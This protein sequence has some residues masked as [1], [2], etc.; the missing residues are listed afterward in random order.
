MS[1]IYSLLRIN[2]DVIRDFPLQASRVDENQ[3]EKIINRN[4]RQLKLIEER[5]LISKGIKASPQSVDSVIKKV[6][7]LSAEN[8]IS[9]EN[10]SIRELRIISYYL[11]KL[12]SNYKDY[13]YALSLL[14]FNWRN[15]FF[16]GLVFYI[17]NS[18]NYIEDELRESTSQLIIKKLKEYKDNNRRYLLLKNHSNFFEKS[19]PK[20]MA[21]L[22]LTK[23]IDLLNAPQILGFKNTAIKQ[24]FY[25]DVILHY[26]A[27]KRIT[28]LEVIE[29]L[30]NI[31]DLDRTKKLVCASLVENANRN[32]DELTRTLLCRFINRTLGDVTL[33]STWAPFSGA[34]KEEA[35]RLKKA[36][37]LVY[38]WFAQRIIEVFFDVCVQ[39]KERKRFWLKYVHHLSGFKLVGSTATKRLLQGDSRIGSMFFKHFIETNSYKS[40]TSA[41]ILFVKNK[42]MVEFSDT[43]ALYVYN[44]EHSQVK[45]VNSH[46]FINSTNDLKIPS[47]QLLVESDYYYTHHNEEGRLHHRGDWQ[48]RLTYWLNDKVLSQSNNNISFWETKDDEIFKETPLTDNVDIYEDD[49]EEISASPTLVSQEV[50]PDRA[51]EEDDDDSILIEQNLKYRISSKWF[52]NK[53]RIVANEKGF[54]VNVL[55]QSNYAK[56]KSFKAGE[57]PSGDIWVRKTN[58]SNWNEVALFCFGTIT[59]IGYINT[60]D[61]RILFKES[62]EL[63][64]YKEIRL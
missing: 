10:W 63:D 58:S 14:D 54:F 11:M 51:I 25:S 49:S 12:R 38:M 4:Q 1:D 37:K 46:K 35:Q 61:S 28:N 36:M 15:M 45:F 5:M 33:A 29:E 8:D 50:I 52:N 31:H 60:E 24:S 20:R 34:S 30:L 32:G 2:S 6:K 64:S 47:I 59:N 18:W 9:I 57:K 40:Q 22:L 43:G 27:S 21:A 55:G 13:H 42:M 48:N 17:M 53:Y 16:N 3:L 23:E 41:L 19:G 39:D 62:L 26:L 7:R 56:I 44:Q